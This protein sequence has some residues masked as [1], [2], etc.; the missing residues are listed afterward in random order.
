MLKT[1]ADISAVVVSNNEGELLRNCLLSIA[2]CKEIIVINLQNDALTSEIANSFDCRLIQDKKFPLV[3]LAHQ[4]IHDK[5]RFDWI[6]MLDPDETLSADLAQELIRLLSE[7]DQSKETGAI[8]VPWRFYFKKHL[9]LGT[10][11]GGINKKTCL[12][13]RRR[14]IFTGQVHRGI[15]LLSG[16]EKVNIPFRQDNFIHHYWMRT[17]KSFFEK[18]IRYLRHERNVGSDE[19]DRVKLKEILLEPYR[20]F[21][22]SY[23]NKRGYRD[24]LMGIFLSLFWMMYTTL[25]KIQKFRGRK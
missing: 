9:L 12:V 18:H 16:Y 24:G 14:S 13:H 11:W 25:A 17:Y 19:V 8:E 1:Q 22:F 5:T 10:T 7:P 3:E 4:W 6:L 21:R 20:A 2:F 23:L 15:E